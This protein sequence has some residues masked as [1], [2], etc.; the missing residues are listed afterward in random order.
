MRFK[1]KKIVIVSSLLAVTSLYSGE[2]FEPIKI[3]AE[4]ASDFLLKTL[5]GELK[6]QVT[7]GNLV[8]AVDF[9]SQQALN[10]TEQVNEKLKKE[11]KNVRLRRV[12]IKNRSSINKPTSEE[13]KILLMLE[14]TPSS[15]ITKVEDKS[16]TYK[17]YQPIKIANEM[18]LKCHGTVEDIS[19]EVR[20]KIH[21]TY[22]QDL[23]TG[24]KIGDLRGAVIVTITKNSESK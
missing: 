14:K 13:A 3:D 15:V 6:K 17:Y 23:A 4:L 1:F 11:G 12:S 24:Y 19:P 22:P 16:E 5:G 18:C 9:C 7:T 8:N 21:E 2:N 20:K 10:I